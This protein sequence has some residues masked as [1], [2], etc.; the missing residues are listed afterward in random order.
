MFSNYSILNMKI[1]FLDSLKSR[2]M[3]SGNCKSPSRFQTC[4]LQTS[5]WHFNLLYY[6]VNLDIKKEKKPYM[7]DYS[8]FYCLFWEKSTSQYWGVLYLSKFSF[9]ISCSFK[10]RLID[11]YLIFFLLKKD[12]LYDLIQLDI[13]WKLKFKICIKMLV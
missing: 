7:Y 8:P 5:Y 12:Q 2:Y 1:H 13:L 9:Y 4:E 11:L 3:Y 10:L 6:T